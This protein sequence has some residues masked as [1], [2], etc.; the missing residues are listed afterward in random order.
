[1]KMYKDLFN[2]PE[3]RMIQ[4]DDVQDLNKYPKNSAF[5]ILDDIIGSGDSMIGTADYCTS[6]KKL[7]KDKFIIFVPITA[8][9]TGLANVNKYITKHSRSKNDTIIFLDK[10]VLEK[11]DGYKIFKNWYLKMKSFFGSSNIN[12]KGFKEQALNVSFPYMAPDNNSFISA[13]LQ[14]LFLVNDSCIKNKPYSFEKLKKKAADYD[15]FGQDEKY[16]L[17]NS[18]NDKAPTF[19]DKIKF[20]IRTKLRKEK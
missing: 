20:L 8:T 7:N 2:F 5:L 19:I 17:Q 12:D 9:E 16:I 14:D 13:N 6:A 18:V 15:L 3:S 4:A 10:N 11:A 1:M